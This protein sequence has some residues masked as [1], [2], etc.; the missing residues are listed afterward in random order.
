M[1]ITGNKYKIFRNLDIRIVSL[2]LAVTLWLYASTERYYKLT[3]HCPVE[4]KNI[5]PGYSLARCLPSVT[6]DIEARGKDLVAFQFKKPTVVIDAEN[7]QIKKFKVK[8]TPNHLV[9]P[10]RLKVR[11]VQFLDQEMEI[12]L[13][14]QTEKVVN[15]LLDLVGDPADGFVL[16]DS[17][18]YEPASALLKG[19]ARQ[20][21]MLDAIYSAPIRVEGFSE[22]TL[23]RSALMLPDSCLFAVSPE[24]IDVFLRFEKSGERVFK[25]IPLSVINRSRDYLVS[26]A[27]GTIDLVVSGPRNIL[28]ASKQSDL[29]ITLDLKDLPP[30]KHQLQATIELPD[31]LV[32]IAASPKDF[33][34]NIR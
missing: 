12:N 28:D 23:V 34:V 26:F 3:F 4:V 25:N 14:R 21:E 19:P 7:R 5:P 11:S 1:K 22:G 18:R 17:I 15:I 8:L 24:S 32:L 6:C 29:K 20:L 16:S 2:V 9:L 13:D 10:F 30:G 33:E 31:K 27:P